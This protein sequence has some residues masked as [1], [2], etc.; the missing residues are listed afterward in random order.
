MMSPDD[1]HA[2]ALPARP[3]SV[4]A[5]AATVRPPP[6]GPAPSP[7]HEAEAREA[8]AVETAAGPREG[9]EGEVLGHPL[10]QDLM[11]DPTG[12]RIW[13]AVAVLR[14]L[15]NKSGRAGRRLVYR[16]R[17]SLGFAGSEISDVAIRDGH[18]ELT[19]NAPGLATAGSSLPA[20]DIARIIADKRNGGAISAWL[21]GPSDLFMQVLEAMLAQSNA[22]FALITGGHVDAFMLLA[23]VVGRSA[24][25]SAGENGALFETRRRI[26]EGAVGLAGMFIGPTSASGLAGLFRAF[27]GLAARI[28]EFAGGDVLTARPARVGQ[29]MGAMLGA[30]CRLPSAGI[31]IHLDGGANPDAQK[32]AREPVR[33]RSLHLLASSYIGGPSVAVRLFLWLDPGNAPPATL[34]DSTAFG[35]LAVLG[36][37]DR[38]VRLP[39]EV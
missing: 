38:R 23:D 18:L 1:M 3:D 31:E 21:D 12:W 9:G 27:T 37:A 33:R 10:V 26:P 28:E 36:V 24:P 16:S 17:P 2:G 22:P 32:W 7:E 39:L 5:E 15:Q 30:Q 6:F 4:S 25:L 20:T 29:R 35:G 34:A 8:E 11:L 19:L 14:W 13:P